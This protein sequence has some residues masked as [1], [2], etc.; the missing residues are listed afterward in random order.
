MV[1]EHPNILSQFDLWQVGKKTY[2]NHYSQQTR[3]EAAKN[4]GC[5]LRQ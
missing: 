1:K 4:L 2:K 3:A 5:G